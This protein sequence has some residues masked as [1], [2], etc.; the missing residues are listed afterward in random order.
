MS[1]ESY[2]NTLMEGYY[3]NDPI[4]SRIDSFSEQIEDAYYQE[5]EKGSDHET[6]VDHAVGVALN[7]LDAG[8]HE[9]EEI[10]QKVREALD[11]NS[12]DTDDQ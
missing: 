12:P 1:T 10:S 9:K 11:E 4:D 6:A 8:E 2:I 3:G 7:L 5:L